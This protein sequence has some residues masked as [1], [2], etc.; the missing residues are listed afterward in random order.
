[1]RM[2]ISEAISSY[3][4]NSHVISAYSKNKFFIM[5]FIQMCTQSDIIIY[6]ITKKVKNVVNNRGQ[7]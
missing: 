6:A 3:S 4:T 7:W 1:M 2:K 5:L